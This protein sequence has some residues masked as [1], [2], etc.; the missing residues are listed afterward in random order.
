MP[1]ARPI[2]EVRYTSKFAKVLRKM[3]LFVQGAFVARE[4]F[5]RENIFYPLLGTHKLG[6]KYKMFWAFTVVGQYRVMFAFLRDDAVVFVNI[7]THAIYK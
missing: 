2:S 5:V 3:P 7:G 1:A 4:Q 6:G